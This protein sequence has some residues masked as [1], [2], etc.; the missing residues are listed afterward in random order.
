MKTCRFAILY[1]CLLAAIALYCEEPWLTPIERHRLIEAEVRMNA[2]KKQADAEREAEKRRV[3]IT[4]LEAAA[5]TLIE[6]SGSK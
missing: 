3:V 1:A 2:Q 4:L 5:R 6:L